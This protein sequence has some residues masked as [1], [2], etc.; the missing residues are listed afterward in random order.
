MRS[1]RS[2]L[3]IS[4]PSEWDRTYTVGKRVEKGEDTSLANSNHLICLFFGSRDESCQLQIYTHSPFISPMSRF[5]FDHE[6]IDSLPRP[7]RGIYTYTIQLCKTSTK[8][9]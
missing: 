7:I 9:Q 3:V 2:W 1:W 8:E 6:L 5:L 4:L